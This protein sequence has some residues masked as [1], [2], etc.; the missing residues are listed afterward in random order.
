MLDYLRLS[1]YQKFK[2]KVDN[3]NE[4]DVNFM[5]FHMLAA[6][7]GRRVMFNWFVECSVMFFG[8]IFCSATWISL[9]QNTCCRLPEG[10]NV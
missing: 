2:L 6:A 7:V 10:R 4:V 3:Q 5:K 8:Q 9:R 1:V